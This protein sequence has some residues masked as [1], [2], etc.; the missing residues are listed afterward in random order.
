MKPLEL[1]TQIK[2]ATKDQTVPSTQRK[3]NT[4]GRKSNAA[5]VTG[6]SVNQDGQIIVSKQIMNKKRQKQNLNKKKKI[7]H[8]DAKSIK[9]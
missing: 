1:H 6:Q 8:G 9:Q 5:P 3:G 2:P 4:T 7:M